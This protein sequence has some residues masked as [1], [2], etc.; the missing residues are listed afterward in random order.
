MSNTEASPKVQ[1]LYDVGAH[2]AYGKSRRHPSA[3]PFIFGTKNKS[4]IFDLEG[5]AVALDKALEFV[6]TLAAAGKQILFIGG[7]NEVVTIVKAG[8]EKAGVPFVAGRWIGGTLT[9]PKQIRSRI[10][11]MKELLHERDAGLRDKYTK[12]ERVLIDRDID[13]LE[14]RFGGLDTMEGTPAALFVIDTRHERIAVAEANQRGIPVIGLAS[15]DCD[16]SKIQYPIP[17]ND[18]NMKSVSY[19]VN[20]V[21]TAYRDNLRP[22]LKPVGTEEK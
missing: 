3:A 5:T 7:K 6:V 21:A 13:N 17:A 20:A 12:K 11:K 15:S 2:F 22:A 1:A 8:A 19:I 16:F 18:T 4:D 14:F 10:E 9:N